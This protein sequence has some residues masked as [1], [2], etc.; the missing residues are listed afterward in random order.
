MREKV[1]DME[2][3]NILKCYKPEVPDLVHDR[4]NE[5]LNSLK[6]IDNL[7]A[8]T[9]KKSIYNNTIKK[10][11]A[12]ALVVIT[13]FGVTMQSYAK[14]VPVLQS[15]LNYFHIGSGY[16]NVTNEFGVSEESNGV[17]I[18]VNSVIYDGYELLVSYT[19]ESNKPLTEKPSIRN[20][21]TKALIYSGSNKGL[22]SL[23]RNKSNV[24]F[25]SEYGEFTGNDKK[26]YSGVILYRIAGNNFDSNEKSI[27]IKEKVI[28]SLQISREKIP[29]KF[30]LDIDI[31]KVGN[32]QGNWDFNLTVENKKTKENIKEIVVNKDLSSLFP[33]TKL[34]KVIVTPI[35]VY[36]QG[37][38]SRENT[39]FDYIAVNDK[40]NILN[41]LGGEVAQYESYGK[42]IGS[43]RNAD[44]NSKS[45]TII[46]YNYFQ[47]K[48]NEGITLNLKGETRI[49]LG[50]NKQ[51]I[52][53]KAEEKDGKTYVHFKSQFP[54]NE[55]LPFYLV[56]EQGK[57]YMRNIDE[58]VSGTKSN[59][60]VLVF[61]ETLLNKRIKVINNTTIYYDQAFTIGIK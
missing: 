2:V 61:D 55:Y 38:V 28:D 44:M 53:T 43:F 3:K 20:N 31:S 49:P 17:K 6:K 4:I 10:G 5:T 52:I 12:A 45:I 56:D 30:T 51:L 25:S 21:S 32:I 18:A 41:H 7:E 37:T 39:F 11:A 36:L 23:F 27:D 47:G 8:K 9:S 24:S 34:E 22:T 1:F 16:N 60:S 59:E 29:D 58:S 40:N 14:N 42:Y 15:A 50:S 33:N 19:V 13:I 48:K 46:P 57:T 35:S 54:I 26:S